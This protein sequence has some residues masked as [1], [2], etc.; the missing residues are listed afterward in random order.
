MTGTPD[1]YSAVL[2]DRGGNR[3][4]LFRE[5]REIFEAAVPQDVIPALR[6]VEAALAQ[7]LYAA[8]GI[9]YEAA[10]AFDPALETHAP[11]AFPLLWFGIYPPPEPVLLPSA[12]A[13]ESPDA[14]QPSVGQ[15][16]YRHAIACI[17]A[18]IAAGDTYQV[19][20]SFR[21][22]ANFNGDLWP[23]FLHMAHAQQ[24]CPGVFIRTPDWS[25]ASASPEYFFEQRNG[26]LVSRP[27]KGTAPRKPSA[28]AD[29][30]QA[31]WLQASEKN[32]AE[33]VMITDMARND[34]GRIAEPGSVEVPAIFTAER[35]PTVWQMTS[36]VACT[37]H[38]GLTE[39]FRA[40]FPPA[41]ITGAPKKRAME[42]IRELETTPRN[43]YT[44][45]L[46]F[47]GP[48]GAQFN[49]AIR[50]VLADH[51]TGRLEYGVGGGIVWDSTDADEYE[52]CRTKA[53]ILTRKMPDF[54][55]LESLLWTPGKGYFLLARHL[56]RL[57]ESAEYF[58]Y[59]LEESAVREALDALAEA[60]PAGPRK[61]R[62]LLDRHGAVTLSHADLDAAAM[63][64][65]IRARLA[66]KPV[67]RDDVFLYHKTTHRHVYEAARAAFPDADEALLWNRDGEV[68]EFTTGNLVYEMAGH[69]YT[70]P[71]SSGLLAGT[72][73]EELLERGAIE[74][75]PLHKDELAA[76]DALFFINS[77]R[78]ER[79][80][81]MV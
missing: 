18:Y 17:R 31:A 70:P 62:L 76:C 6:R 40:L 63:P 59:A 8:G 50:T 34:L 55:L 15:E 2:Y 53:A 69:R 46:G 37:Y 32:R 54:S 56:K 44:G 61:V 36:T 30:A 23:F 33:N 79:R 21:L 26:R 28:S 25:A 42:I 48:D 49:V 38:G 60:M 14:W 24:P 12:P 5:A 51:R 52:E 7:G 57:E 4:L 29:R 16:A 74:D 43:F 65:P 3:W 11:G 73:R 47:A 80:V 19:N 58:G 66:E 41:S 27:M 20:Y 77:V 71:V 67:R 35:Y 68:T 75:R 39:I 9:A 10:S 1:L 64:D 45:A 13:A 78:G 81:R 72:S 22:H